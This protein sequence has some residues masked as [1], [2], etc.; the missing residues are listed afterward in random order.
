MHGKLNME[1]V[2][3]A[4]L[5]GG[6]SIGSASDLVV[7]AGVAMGIGA[8]AGIISA[9]GFLKLNGW[10]REKIGLFDTCGVHNLHGLPGVLGGVI[11]AFSSAFADMA[12]KK[13]QVDI[14]CNLLSQTFPA[15]KDCARTAAGQGWFQL[16]ALGITLA[17]SISS[18]A[19]SGFIASKVGN[20][21]TYFT[22]DEHWGELEYD[23]VDTADKD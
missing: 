5:A 8:L 23:I 22:D 11:G 2:L 6:V 21:D 12:F 17:I 10:L 16:A 14:N 20:V 4:T 15:M 9:L 3:N 13:D 19:L 7:T 1:V 18:G